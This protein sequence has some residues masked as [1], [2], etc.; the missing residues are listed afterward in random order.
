MKGK[1]VFG[2][3]LAMVVLVGFPLVAFYFVN[4][5]VRYR[6]DLSKSLEDYGLIEPFQKRFAAGKVLSTAGNVTVLCFP[7]ANTSKFFTQLHDQFDN[8]TDVIFIVNGIDGIEDTVQVWDFPQDR[9]ADLAEAL[10]EL[11]PTFSG[12]GYLINREGRL[13]KKYDL[14]D[15]DDNQLFVKHIG[16][17]LPPKKT[18]KAELIRET[19]K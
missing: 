12:E 14:T 7:T 8:R 11:K 9:Q 6:K 18:L 3:F 13:V 2:S 10:S 19:E 1:K 5:G 17:F 4:K 16:Y 15:K